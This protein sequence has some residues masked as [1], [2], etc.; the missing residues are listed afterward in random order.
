[1]TDKDKLQASGNNGE[2]LGKPE[3]PDVKPQPKRPEVNTPNKPE[4]SPERKPDVPSTDE[5]SVPEI[6]PDKIEKPEIPQPTPKE[7]NE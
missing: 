7:P 5:P 4:V 3:A 6:K 1:M 2:K